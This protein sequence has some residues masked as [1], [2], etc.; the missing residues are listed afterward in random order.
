MREER[1][2]LRT[3]DTAR[4][5]GVSELE[6]VA[7]MVGVD[8]RDGDIPSRVRRLRADLPDILPRI[9]EFGR[10]MALTRN[11]LFVHEKKGLY[12]NVRISAHVAQVLDEEIDLRIFASRWV[13]ALA[14]AA[15]ARGSVRHSLQFFD[16]HGVAVHKTF[17]LEDSDV[18]A[19]EALVGDLLREDQS[20]EQAVE[21]TP[22]PPVERPDADVDVVEIEKAWHAI[23]D[24]H[25][26]FRIL[27]DHGVTRTQA[28]RLV[29]DELA[30]PAANSALRTVL[31]A[32]SAEE[33]PLMIF[34]RSPGTWQIHH[35]PVNRIEDSE[36]W[37]NVLDPD[38]S[39]HARE[40]EIDAS[41]VVRKPVEAGWVTSLEIFDATGRLSAILFGIRHEGEREDERWRSL[42]RGL[43]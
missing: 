18:D 5:I 28:F 11:D 13:H 1:P 32:A 17:L 39:L 19:Y 25:D 8:G 3:R 43:A 27:D 22:E 2:D 14:V 23:E 30:R 36:P 41:W 6:L 10:V 21:P 29:G 12:R 33:I 24:T 20:P 38:F 7:S 42:V 31:E 35:G 26:F 4:E 9:E 40:D 16:A 15:R 34:V 37:L